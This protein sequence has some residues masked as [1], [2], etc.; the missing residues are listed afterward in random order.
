LTHQ[1][2]HTAG[3]A[4]PDQQSTDG[5]DGDAAFL[6]RHGRI[7]VKP[8]RGEQGHGV[9]ADLRTI[10]E[11]RAAVASAK[12]FCPEVLLESF[13]E[14]EDLRIIVIDYHVVAAAVR[15]RPEVI[16]DGRSELA[17]LIEKYNR[18]RMAATGGESRVPLDAETDRALAAAGCTM[19]TVLPAGKAV[20]LRRA[21]NLHTGGTIHDV[22]A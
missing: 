12:E 22:T 6:A 4:V 11:V 1:T 7:V 13:A 14:G 16:G 10:D 18:R 20:E 5:G 2:L 15:R 8:C 17:R 3:L 19:T 9:S 21:A